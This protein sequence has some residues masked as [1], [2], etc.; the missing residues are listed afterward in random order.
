MDLDRRFREANKRLVSGTRRERFPLFIQLSCHA[1][2]RCNYFNLIFAYKS[3]YSLRYKLDSTFRETMKPWLLQDPIHSK[4]LSLPPSL[5]LEAMRW[6]VATAAAIHMNQIIVNEKSLRGIM[7]ST[8]S[9]FI[10]PS[11]LK[12]IW[13][14]RV[15]PLSFGIQDQLPG[16]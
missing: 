16:N 13:R 14:T 2:S 10:F 9:L 8:G 11:P 3:N 7:L 6:R 4:A 15:F 5:Y 1:I 12:T